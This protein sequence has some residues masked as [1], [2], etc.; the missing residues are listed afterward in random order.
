MKTARLDFR[1]SEEQKHLFEQAT[2]LGDYKSLTDFILATLQEK[3]K[4]IIQEKEQILASERD[5]EI[6]FKAMINTPKPN[7]KLS[8]AME[9]YKKMLS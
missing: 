8:E 7:E 1:L 3:A 9:S 6:F 4:K 5:K 2:L